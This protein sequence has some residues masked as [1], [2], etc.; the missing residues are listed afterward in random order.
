ME[1]L[2]EGQE[3]DQGLPRFHNRARMLL[4]STISVI[5]PLRGS[6]KNQT[7][8][9][10]A[11]IYIANV[12]HK[13]IFNTHQHRNLTPSKSSPKNLT[14]V[15]EFKADFAQQNSL[16]RRHAQTDVKFGC[17]S[18]KT[19]WKMPPGSRWENF[20]SFPFKI[21][22]LSLTIQLRECRRQNTDVGRWGSI[23]LLSAGY[24][25]KHS[26]GQTFDPGLH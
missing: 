25:E 6:H 24:V 8:W 12:S 19:P 4:Y 17:F 10:H 18:T 21:K 23:S 3:R 5:I 7:E 16:K 9:L 13:H 2:H 26:T 14:P 15:K 1:K 20:H 22:L 11:K